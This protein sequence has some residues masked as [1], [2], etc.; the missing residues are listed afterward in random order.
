MHHGF[1]QRLDVGNEAR[2]S[3]VEYQHEGLARSGQLLHQLAL[4]LRE[5]QVVQVARSLAIAV[6]ADA[7][8]NDVGIVGGGY[9][10]F[11]LGSILLVVSAVLVVGD[12]LLKDDVV[13]SELVAESLVDGVV[14]LSKV[15]SLRA[16]PRVAPSAVQAT[17][18]VGIGAGEQNILAKGERQDVVLVLQ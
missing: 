6:L 8:H 11:N 13:G 18:L 17:H 4:I 10:L 9:R 1:C 2:A 12:T 15:F 14:A 7:G 5:P 3:L 16:L